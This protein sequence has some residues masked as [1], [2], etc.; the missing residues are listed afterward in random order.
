MYESSLGP[1]ATRAL[2]SLGIPIDRNA[3]S[4]AVR[5]W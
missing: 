3:P 4:V 2:L 1:T 5:L